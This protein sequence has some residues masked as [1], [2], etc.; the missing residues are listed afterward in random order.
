MVNIHMEIL[1]DCNKILNMT[2]WNSYDIKWD[3]KIE[4]LFAPIATEIKNFLKEKKYGDE[5]DMLQNIIMCNNVMKYGFKKR[6]KFSR[7]ERFIYFDVYV[8]YETYMPKAEK[9]RKIMIAECFLA[10]MDLLSKYKPK[11][12]ILADLKKDFSIFFESIGWL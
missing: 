5:I 1:K 12:F 3:C 2:Y 8:D 7:K 4:K 11:N 9:D 10:D 6:S